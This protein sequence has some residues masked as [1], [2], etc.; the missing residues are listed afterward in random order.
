[1]AILAA[2]EAFAEA[3]LSAEDPALAISYCAVR[4]PN[5]E[6]T[7][8]FSCCRHRNVENNRGLSIV[9]IEMGIA[10]LMAEVT[11]IGVSFCRC[12]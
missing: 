9:M 8:G 1:V 5:K 6:H 7:R 3:R 4:Y 10:E 11:R 12:H 2:S